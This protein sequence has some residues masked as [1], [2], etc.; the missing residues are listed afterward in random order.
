MKKLLSLITLISVYVLMFNSC[1]KEKCETENLGTHTF[2]STD[3]QIIPYKGNDKLVFSDSLGDTLIYTGERRISSYQQ[4]S[5]DKYYP[6]GTDSPCKNL[7]YTTENS[8]IFIKEKTHNSDI[9][10]DLNF[11]GPFQSFEKV[12]NIQIS[13]EEN[14]IYWSFNQNYVFNTLQLFSSTNEYTATLVFKAS[15]ILGNKTFNS[16]YILKQLINHLNPE[17]ANLQYVYYTVAQGIVGFRTKP[18]GRTW[19]LNN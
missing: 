5:V 3:L 11:E 16:V 4:R 1:K 7:I 12:I 14:T 8:S 6:N 15:L 9:S 17:N 19:Y 13:Y 18:G 2:T 10:L